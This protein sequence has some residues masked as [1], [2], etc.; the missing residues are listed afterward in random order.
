LHCSGVQYSI[1]TVMPPWFA[2][3]W[4]NTEETK[5]R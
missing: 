1:R 3:Y 5:G 4:Y 2:A